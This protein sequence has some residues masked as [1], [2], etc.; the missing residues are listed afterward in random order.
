MALPAPLGIDVLWMRSV[1]GW[2]ILAW[3]L[4]RPRK[5]PASPKKLERFSRSGGW[6]QLT[7]AV[8]LVVSGRTLLVPTLDPAKTISDINNSDFFADIDI[9]LSLT[10]SRNNCVHSIMSLNSLP[11]ILELSMMSSI[12]IFG[13]R[14]VRISEVTVWKVDGDPVRPKGIHFCVREPLPS[15]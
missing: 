9:D 13:S 10:H 14:S 11:T 6:H 8:S 12:L 2:A 1:S 5:Y 7:I 15:V 3:P 4:M